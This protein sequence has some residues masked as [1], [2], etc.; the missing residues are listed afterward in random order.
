MK[1]FLSTKVGTQESQSRSKGDDIV[2]RVHASGMFALDSLSKVEDFENLQY[3][4]S[5]LGQGF[6]ITGDGERQ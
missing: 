6:D 3:I 2:H 1:G 4:H 5:G